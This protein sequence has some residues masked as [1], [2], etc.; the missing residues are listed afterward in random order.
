MRLV[1][2]KVDHYLF[3]QS[4]LEALPMVGSGS[5]EPCI[6][7]LRAITALTFAVNWPNCSIN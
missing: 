3:Q 5:R 1:K 6:G 7:T 4:I 2:V